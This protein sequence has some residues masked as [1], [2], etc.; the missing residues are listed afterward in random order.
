MTEP[1]HNDY[2]SPNFHP[3]SIFKKGYSTPK[4]TD[5]DVAEPDFEFLSKYLKKITIFLMLKKF[6][7]YIIC[8]INIFNYS[9]LKIRL[10]YVTDNAFLLP[11]Q[12]I[13][14]RSDV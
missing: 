1:N 4:W 6:K 3:K 9:F 7:N 14:L 5:Y 8:K 12:F 2:E 10:L 11:M 13:S